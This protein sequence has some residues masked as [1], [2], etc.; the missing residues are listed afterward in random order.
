[1]LK[2][3]DFKRYNYWLFI[4]VIIISVFGAFMIRSA[5]GES[6]FKRQLVGITVGIIGMFI[7][8]LIDYNFI[9]KFYWVI[10]AFN[11]VLLVLVKI[12]GKEVK[13]A[14]RWIEIVKDSVSIQP[15]EFTKIFLILILAKFISLH[16]EKLNNFSFLGLTA[17]VFGVPILL[18]VSQPDLS[19]TVLIC[20]VLTTM[21]YCAGL[22]YKNI[23]I[24]LSVLIPLVLGA[25]LYIQMPEQKLLKDY[26]FKRIMAFINPEEY[27]DD[28]YQQDYSVQAIGSGQL[29]GKGYENDDPNSIKNAG[30]IA[31]A[32]N[33]F[34]FA[35]IGEELGFVGG[36]FLIVLLMI[37]VYVCVYISV[38][39]KDFVGR[40]ICCG[41]AAF[42]AY[43][44]F[45][46]IGVATEILPNTGIPLPFVSKGLSSL[47]GIYGGMGIILNIS[48]QKNVD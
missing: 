28:R 15:S 13:G 26:Q 46:N 5:G 32:Q 40:L 18:V 22:K 41:M 29:Y 37:I 4:I 9:L 10:Y 11:I 48:L 16:R 36:C 33:D 7:V 44:S 1:M 14:Q 45:M 38:E 17:V 34:I 21:I 42:I 12:I 39:A 2:K 24:I 20:A 27:D 8:S 3:Y 6:D 35:V 23:L 43:Q 30:Y 31:E 19:T 47:I 25:V